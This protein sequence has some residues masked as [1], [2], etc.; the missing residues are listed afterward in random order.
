M[1]LGGFF[2]IMLGV[3]HFKHNTCIIFH[4]DERFLYSIF[5]L[6][7]RRQFV[8]IMWNIISKK[9]NAFTKSY[10]GVKEGSLLCHISVIAPKGFVQ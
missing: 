3:S 8:V 6:N 10:K 9:E 1:C 2:V 5:R 4:L 7:E